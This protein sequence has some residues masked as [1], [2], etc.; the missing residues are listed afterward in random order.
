M[1]YRINEEFRSLSS[2][3]IKELLPEAR[4]GCQDSRDRL[5][6]EFYSEVKKV[7]EQYATGGIQKEDLFADGFLA[8]DM[9]IKKFDPTRK[10]SFRTYVKTAIKN[11]IS[12]SDILFS[13][14][15][16][17]NKFKSFFR[18]HYKITQELLHEL[19]REPTDVDIVIRMAKED[20]KDIS[21]GEKLSFYEKKIEEFNQFLYN[22]ARINLDQDM[23][24]GGT[25]HDTVYV[26]EEDPGIMEVES[27]MEIRSIVETIRNGM[28]FPFESTKHIDYD[29]LMI[30]L[31]ENFLDEDERLILYHSFGYADYEKLT[32]KEISKRLTK[33]LVPQNISKKKSRI[34]TKLRNFF[35]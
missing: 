11:N 35:Y 2:K 23:E 31:G 3:E 25:Y 29:K 12:K 1:S 20:D 5:I 19:Q 7:A 32:A 10:T 8:V 17:P 28:Q 16:V 9:C 24:D 13:T 30:E 18:W 21:M 33:P 6:T 14:M 22:Q 27:D 26:H 34:I 15:H 4:N